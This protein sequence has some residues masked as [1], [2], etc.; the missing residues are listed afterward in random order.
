MKMC[1]QQI[2][3]NAIRREDGAIIAEVYFLTSHLI[4]IHPGNSLH[5]SLPKVY[6]MS[7]L[8]FYFED[9]AKK[10]L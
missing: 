7:L 6:R 8:F 1:H 5:Q 3:L 10:I 9:V 4:K 2:C